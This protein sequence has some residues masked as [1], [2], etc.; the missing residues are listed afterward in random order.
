MADP[1]RDAWAM[2]RAIALAA[3]GLGRV[4]PN[5][6]VGA[7]LLKGGRLVAEGYHH[8][9]GGP[10]AEVEV[11]QAAGA[12]AR[13]ADL[14]VTLE[15]CCHWGKTPPCTDAILAAGIRRVVAAA[16]DP[17]PKVAGG[18]FA[19]LREAGLQVEVGLLRQEAR[20][21]NAA[22]FKR[23]ETG[24]PLVIAK[25][26][27]TLDGR[28]ATA[29]GESRWISSDESRRRVHEIRRVV[30]AVLVGAGTV[31]KDS[32][33]LTV[34]H[35]APLPERGQ[36]ARVVLDDRLA[37]PP[38]SEPARSARQVPVLVY[39]TAEAVSAKPQAAAALAEAGCIVAPVPPAAGGVAV[40]AVLEDLA[41]RGMSRVL[42]E[43]GARVFGAF[44]AE[45][46]VDR[47]MVFVSPRLLAGADALGPVAGPPGR[48][49]AEALRVQDLSASAVGPDVL[50]EGRLGTY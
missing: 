22:Y 13:G 33:E 18:G 16:E 23:Q 32:P 25:W 37:V 29:A 1:E 35:V 17:F 38:A 30:D 24:L 48:A 40:R 8:R 9:F 12:A 21:M 36:P 47:L 11:L 14:Y 3:G 5:P 27:M 10:H 31:L 6:M 49:L 20:R 41:R 19:R 28:I 50:L 45:G 4:E 44:L 39:T 46:L 26:A 34:R 7:V 2:G 43:G 15:P 42:V